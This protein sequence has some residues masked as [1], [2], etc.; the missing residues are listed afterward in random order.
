MDEAEIDE[1]IM[2]QYDTEVIVVYVILGKKKRESVEDSPYPITGELTK[3]IAEACA[4]KYEKDGVIH[5]NWTIQM[6]KV[7]TC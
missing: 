3:G 2:N 4:V 6:I 1:L 7:H 5:P